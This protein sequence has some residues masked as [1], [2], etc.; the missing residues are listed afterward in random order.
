MKTE[1]EKRLTTLRSE[2]EKGQGQLRQLEEK[3]EEIKQT[4]LRISGA[5]QVLEE[6]LQSAAGENGVSDSEIKEVVTPN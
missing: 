1:I 5:I 6:T 4:L 3:S 2:F